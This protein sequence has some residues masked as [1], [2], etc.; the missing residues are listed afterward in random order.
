M[1]FSEL[2]SDLD[3]QLTTQGPPPSWWPVTGVL[4]TSF[5]PSKL[6]WYSPQFNGQSQLNGGD[7]SYSMIS[8]SIDPMHAY[9]NGM[10]DRE[11]ET[12]VNPI[13]VLEDLKLKQ[14]MPNNIPLI[15]NR[16]TVIDPLSPMFRANRPKYGYGEFT[17]SDTKNLIKLAAA[18]ALIYYFLLRK[19]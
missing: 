12:E 4:T 8:T 19:K 10:G 7:P 2:P 14:Q 17:P 3:D 15:A 18:A 6:R 11:A 13:E 16:Y 1:R 5:D 9:F